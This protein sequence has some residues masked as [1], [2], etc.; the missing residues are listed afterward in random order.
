MLPRI[1][2]A[3]ALALAGCSSGIPTDQ[4]YCERF[5]NRGAKIIDA[6]RNKAIIVMPEIPFSKE[7][8]VRVTEGGKVLP[9]DALDA[10][11]GVSSGYV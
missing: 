4:V 11:T 10:D 3:L 2:L 7:N 5:G 8:R 6:Q 1:L 9:G